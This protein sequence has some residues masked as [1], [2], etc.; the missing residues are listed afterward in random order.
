[1]T[2]PNPFDQFDEAEQNPFDQFDSATPKP[3][4]GK[5]A[6]GA[7]R[8]FLDQVD[9]DLQRSITREEPGFRTWDTATPEERHRT[10]VLQQYY[11]RAGFHGVG[12]EGAFDDPERVKARKLWAL[13]QYEK[14]EGR[15]PAPKEMGRGEAFA[16]SMV[17]TAVRFPVIGDTAT[18]GIDA[19]AGDYIEGGAKD[20]LRTMKR[21]AR[22][23]HPVSSMTGDVAGYIAPGAQIL[24][25]GSNLARSTASRFIPPQ[26]A[27]AATPTGTST[28]AKLGRYI[29]QTVAPAAIAGGVDYGIYEGSVGANNIEVDTGEVQPFADRIDRTIEYMNP[30]EHPEGYAF[31]AM[32]SPVY[33][34][35]RGGATATRNSV[36]ASLQSGQPS[37]APGSFTS[38]ARQNQVNQAIRELNNSASANDPTSRAYRVVAKALDKDQISQQDLIDALDAFRYNG[39][40]SVDEMLFELASAATNDKGAGKINELVRALATVGG[41][42]Q[43]F[44]RTQ[45]ANRAAGSGTRIRDDI[46]KAAG[47]HGADFDNYGAQ[48]EHASVNLPRPLYDEAYSRTISD[49]SFRDGVL[50]IF[51]HSSQ[52][53]NAISEAADY[54]IGVA[55]SERELVVAQQTA[56]ELARFRVDIDQ[57]RSGKISPDQVGPLSTRSYDYII[58]MLGDA[59]HARRTRQGRTELAKGFEGPA[60]RLRRI[61]DGQTGLGEARSTAAELKAASRALDYGVKAAKNQTALHDIQNEFSKEMR[62]YADSEMDVFEGSTINSAL[63]MGWARGAEDIIER[64]SNPTTAIRQL[65]GSPRQREKMK[66]MLLG[67]DQT[68]IARA[69]VLKAKHPKA[70]DEDIARMLHAERSA[71]STGSS[72]ETMRLRQVVGD[73]YKGNNRRKFEDGDVRTLGRFDREMRMAETNRDLFHKSPTGRNNAAVAEQGGTQRI[74][75]TLLDQ[76][77][78]YAKSP[79]NLAQDTT[80]EIARR[81]TKPA[82]YDEAVNKELGQILFTGG[83]DHLRGIVDALA[84]YRSVPEVPFGPVTGN[85]N[86]IAGALADAEQNMMDKVQLAGNSDQRG[87]I[88]IG[89]GP[90]RRKD[91]LRNLSSQGGDQFPAERSQRLQVQAEQPVSVPPE[92]RRGV[93]DSPLAT[94]GALGLGGTALLGVGNMFQSRANSTIESPAES[95]DLPTIRQKFMNEYADVLTNVN[96]REG[97]IE[98]RM[99]R[100]QQMDRLMER[101]ARREGHPTTSSE[102]ERARQEILDSLIKKITHAPMSDLS[103]YYS[104]LDQ[105]DAL[106]ASGGVPPARPEGVPPAPSLKPALPMQ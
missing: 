85:M 54:A 47:L 46:R 35:L 65:Y 61:V 67:L 30:L 79:I 87:A 102:I 77:F 99:A 97:L 14:N 18:A 98:S 83:E 21:E 60:H 41:D 48:L 25:G 5:I 73:K 10:H 66:E 57:L 4:I 51:S 24:R 84:S 28:A 91:V 19:I 58:R 34:L 9:A 106:I 101:E 45:G 105:I 92:P 86:K 29:P 26:I 49:R 96:A 82:I 37:I 55:R 78:R 42:A 94:L 44:G 15:P 104:K 81:L 56:N 50:P 3:F 74:A 2:Q 16:R 52:A 23:A 88:D 100:V 53:Q 7:G 13:E 17:D 20:Q 8:S 95:A 63:L 39:Y 43:S 6:I 70:T 12:V 68:A 27:K 31:G 40:S 1:M 90:R 22:E 36:E 69:G 38:Q 32:S 80:K 64:A 11:D 33:R 59:G 103:P 93:M 62:R 75:E 76:A 89:G 72:T 71:T